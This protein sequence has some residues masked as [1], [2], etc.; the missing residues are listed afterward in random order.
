MAVVV[1]VVV[2]LVPISSCDDERWRESSRVRIGGKRRFF[3]EEEYG[4]GSAMGLRI[5]MVPPWDLR[6]ESLLLLLLLHIARS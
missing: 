1:V 4:C 3:E 5:A 6:V 2:V